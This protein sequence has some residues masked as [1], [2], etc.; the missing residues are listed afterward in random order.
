MNHPLKGIETLEELAKSG[1]CFPKSCEWECRIHQIIPMLIEMGMDAINPIQ[2]SAEH[3]DPVLLK[4]E[5]GKD[6]VFFGGIDENRI[7]LHGSE[8]EVREETKRILDILGSD[9][10]YIVA[11]S[12]D[13]LLPEVPARNIVAMYDEAKKFGC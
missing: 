10:R 2:V 6:I 4:R 5:Y 12:H 9:G 1:Y 3:M 13:Y 8:Y 7:L 11:A